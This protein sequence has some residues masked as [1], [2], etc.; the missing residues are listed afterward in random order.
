MQDDLTKFALNA[1]AWLGGDQNQVVT[2]VL[3]I[4]HFV[5]FPTDMFNMYYIPLEFP[6]NLHQSRFGVARKTVTSSRYLKQFGFQERSHLSPTPILPQNWVLST[7]LDRL[8]TPADTP[9]WSRDH[10]QRRHALPSTCPSLGTRT[11]SPGRAALV[12]GTLVPLWRSV[13]LLCLQ[14]RE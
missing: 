5:E 4:F 7:S 14:R 1:K 6:R 13:P 3:S 10:Q 8:S 11:R 9:L 2:V 12:W